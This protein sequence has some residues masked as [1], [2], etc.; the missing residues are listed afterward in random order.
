MRHYILI[1]ALSSALLTACNSP[2]SGQDESGSTETAAPPSASH[3]YAD[4]AGKWVGVEG[5]FVTVTPTES[6]TYN[7][8]MQSD[9]D[10][11]GT[12]TGI[13]GETGIEFMRGGETRLLVS[14]TGEDIGLKY[15]LDKTDCL[16][17]KPGEGYCRD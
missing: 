4:W 17:V 2:E 3:A 5:M 15:L 7:L 11:L 14:A 8:V 12:Y 9:L 6:G 13:D 10:T 1:A 16:M